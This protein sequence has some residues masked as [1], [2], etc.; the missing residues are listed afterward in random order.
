MEAKLIQFDEIIKGPFVFLQQVAAGGY[1]WEQG[2]A[3][4]EHRNDERRVKAGGDGS[5]WLVAS[6]PEAGV[7]QCPIWKKPDLYRRFASLPSEAKAINSFANKYGFLG[8]QILLIN[9]NVKA[10]QTGKPGESLF[11]WQQEIEKMALLVKIWD[12]VAQE[13]KLQLAKYFKWP[14]KK[15]VEF[16]WMAPGGGLALISSE[17]IR[18]QLL[19]RWRPG[20]VLGPA[21]FYVCDEI[22]KALCGHVNTAILPFRDC[23]IF[24]NPD[25]LISALYVQFALEVSGRERPAITCKGCGIKFNPTHGRQ[26]YHDDSCRKKKWWRES[27]SHKEKHGSISIM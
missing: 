1:H 4:I 7:R 11:Y 18:P 12:F 5:S 21:C 6:K 20:D 13:K 22:N 16:E 10:S 25:S 15:R 2:L 17:Q 9:P 8:N 3:P 24:M 14:N 27:L 19:E 23:D 26:A